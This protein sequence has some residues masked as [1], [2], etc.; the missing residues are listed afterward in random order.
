MVGGKATDVRREP[1]DVSELSSFGEDAAGEL[2][3]LTRT[4]LGP[5][6]T[7]GEVLRLVPPSG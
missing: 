5:V 7:T 3:V 6:G 4:R 1:F 2:Y